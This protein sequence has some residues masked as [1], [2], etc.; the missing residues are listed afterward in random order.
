MTESKENNSAILYQN[1]SMTITLIDIPKSIALAQELTKDHD[2]QSNQDVRMPYSTSPP[3]APYPS[4]EPKSA[5]RE[6]VYQLAKEIFPTDHLR[7]A[8]TTIAAGTRE[9][10]WS[11]QRKLWEIGVLTTKTNKDQKLLEDLGTTEGWSAEDPLILTE[12]GRS[13]ANV[14]Q[15]SHRL[16]CNKRRTPIELRL[17]PFGTKYR[18][19]PSSAFLLSKITPAT[20]MSFS[21]AA[22]HQYPD[23]SPTTLA[24]P[25]EF[26]VVIL[27]PPWSNRSVRRSRQYRTVEPEE[28]PLG[29]LR[30]ILSHH[31]APGALVACWI[32]NKPAVRDLALELFANW[33]LNVVEEWAWLKVTTKGEPVTDIEGVWRKPY[34]LLLIG[35][36]PHKDNPTNVHDIVRRV[37]VGVPSL[38]SQK[39]H[40]KELIG[41]LLPDNTTDYRV[42]EIFAR[43]L[44]AGWWA[45]GD[46][47]LKF[48]DET[49]WI[50]PE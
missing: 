26:D 28:S 15:I 25:G 14:A 29:A 2:K 47:V 8:L 6:V 9:N 45:W 50:Q 21:M 13:P 36:K 24:G 23:A 31:I 34:E 19:P 27:D 38:H 40:L 33:N 18:I 11:L 17:D 1:G 3:E 7:E 5:K 35:R 32:T 12:Q 41:Q 48:N 46:E 42:F 49:A 10:M 30:S 4:T 44:T 22:L 20:T 43:N 37:V 16:V 39:P